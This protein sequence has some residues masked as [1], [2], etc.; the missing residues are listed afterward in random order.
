[1]NA[2]SYPGPSSSLI[3]NRFMG[4]WLL[5]YPTCMYFQLCRLW[6]TGI[7]LKCEALLFPSPNNV[8]PAL[9]LLVSLPCPGKR[10]DFPVQLEMFWSMNKQVSLF[11]AWANHYIKFNTITV[12]GV[13]Q[14]R[15]RIYWCF[16]EC[17]NTRVTFSKALCILGVEKQWLDHCSADI[18]YF[19]VSLW[20]LGDSSGVKRFEK[21]MQQDYF[22]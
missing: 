7:P 6:G 14:R 8:A 13:K 3:S 19:R 2:H 18:T 1:M 10:C 15:T 5:S 4:Q 20:R 22:C 17:W 16:C 12:A 11:S 21:N 9:V